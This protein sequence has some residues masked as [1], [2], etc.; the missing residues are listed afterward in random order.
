[1]QIAEQAVALTLREWIRRLVCWNDCD[2]AEVHRGARV[3]VLQPD[4]AEVRPWSADGLVPELALRRLLVAAEFVDDDAVQRDTRQLPVQLDL[5]RVPLTHRLLRLLLRLAQRVDRSRLVPFVRTSS[6]DLDLVPVMHA[7][8][9][10]GGG[11][12]HAHDHARVVAVARGLEDQAHCL[13]ADL[14]AC[15]P[16]QAHASLGLHHS[17]LDNE[18]ARTDHLPAGQ[19]LAVEQLLGLSSEKSG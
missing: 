7:V 19:I 1:M 16:K 2:F 9:R 13:I 11:L 3:M 10:I 17:V 4:E 5:H 18:P 15:V 14:A 12:G 8:P 6:V